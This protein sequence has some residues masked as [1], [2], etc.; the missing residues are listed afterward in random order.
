M[1]HDPS[2]DRPI[3]RPR[4]RLDSWKEIA[5]YLRRDV[6]TVQRWEARNS[7]PV[8]RLQHGKLG[9]VFAYTSEIDEWWNAR[10]QASSRPSGADDGRA[11][12]LWRA[13]VVGALAANMLLVAYTAWQS[14]AFRAKGAKRSVPIRSVA[15]LPLADLSGMPGQ[16]YF[17]EGMTDALIAR[18]SSV[19]GVRVISR[20]S[21]MDFN[22]KTRSL[23]EI[24]RAL[25]VE[26]V[27][28][29]S[30]LRTEDR[31]RISTQLV[32]VD[33]QE[34]IWS[35]TYDRE[36]RDVLTLQTDV[37]EA[38]VR[39]IQSVVVSSIDAVRATR[40]VVP[41]AYES[42]LK[43]RFHLNKRNS[44]R[45]DVE[46]SIR[47]F[48]ESIARDP[49]FAPAHA[50]L[51]AAYQDLSA[52]GNGGLPVVETIPKTTA[53]ADRA[54]QLDP[55]LAEAHVTL[56]AA[57]RQAWDWAAAERGLKHALDLNPNDAEAQMTY[58]G[59]LV[60]V[61][62][63]EDG[64]A[65]ARR[66]RELDPLSVRQTVRLAWFLYHA[67]RYDEAI[68]ELK[69]VLDADPDHTNALWFLG[70]ALIEVSRFDEAIATL[71]HAAN[72]ENRNPAVLGVL[73]RAYSRANRRADALRILD[74][75][76][77]RGRSGYV[78]PA[79]FVHAYMGTA[80]RDRIFEALERAYREHSNIMQFLKTH[81]LYDPVRGDPRFGDLLRR[82][83]LS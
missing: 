65:F 39:E 29:G 57:R 79:V 81:P 22:R 52:T 28:D 23:L 49:L 14:M 46:A 74:E 83:G 13:V 53:A 48:E 77:H 42:Y 62:K 43:A 25:N 26:A 40:P 70:F 69:V 71:E 73:A 63:T 1:A 47:L 24:A 3:N 16:E 76:E 45:A 6:R 27:V 7:L 51:A 36:L 59:L 50:G 9:S 2:A 15:V 80:D 33:T 56:A 19:R 58:G 37:A 60:A 20:S 31:V 72:L 8:H 4:V 5:A 75:V 54:L 55:Q 30:V 34:N 64:L 68:R 61:G 11:F 66:G 17:A 32:R 21:V 44:T 41:A 38:I 67:R 10:D 18:L 12:S 78:P 82:V 35:G